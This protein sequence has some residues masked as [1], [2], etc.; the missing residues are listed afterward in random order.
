LFGAAEAQDPQHSAATFSPLLAP[1]DMP[2]WNDGET[3]NES[4]LGDVISSSLI[5]L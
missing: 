1:S 4:W 5:A 3:S 2:S